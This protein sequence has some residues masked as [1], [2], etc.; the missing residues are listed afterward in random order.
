MEGMFLKFDPG[1]SAFSITHDDKILFLGSCFSDEIASIA[2]FSGFHCTS[3]P[4]GTVFHPIPLARFIKESITGLEQERILERDGRF[5][6]WDASTHLSSPS[7]KQLE[8]QLKNVRQDWLDHLK[9]AS[10]LFV[11]FGTAW[12]Y[13]YQGSMI[14]A[15]CHKKPSSE[16]QKDLTEAEVIVELWNEVLELIKII[17]PAL[18]VVFTVSPVRHIRDG[19]IENNQS[20]AILL[21]SIRKINKSSG[22][23]YFPSYEIV[24][25]Q[26]RDYRFYKQDRVHPSDEAVSVVWDQFLRFYTSEMTRE[27][28]KEI[29]AFQRFKLHVPRFADEK[30]IAD[31]ED[32]CTKWASD[33][34]SKYP[35]IRV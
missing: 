29:S 26:L 34:T 23:F 7:I 1:R 16:F 27:I 24:I 12:G 2:E 33:L 17:N 31:Y 20:K 35:N 9:E 3:N 21:D 8:E 32:R 18:K 28:V 30:G 10:V 14:V 15:N 22:S 11:T 6:S 5:F 13:H 25:D 4:F 19:L